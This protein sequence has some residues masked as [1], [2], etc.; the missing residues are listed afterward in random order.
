MIFTMEE[1]VNNRVKFLDNTIS[2]IDQKISFN[3]YIKRIATDIIIPNDSCHPTELKLAAIKYL[4]N[5]ISI[6]PMNETNKIKEYD[7]IKQET[8]NNN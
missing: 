2:K 4:I 7:T 5:R 1:E 3:V 6:Y 8:H